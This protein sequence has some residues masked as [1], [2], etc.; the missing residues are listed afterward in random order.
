MDPAVNWRLAFARSVCQRLRRYPGLRAVIVGGSV[1]RGYADPFSDLEMPLFW[2]S[3]PDDNKRLALADDLGA[4]FAEPYNGPAQED[5]L[6]IQGFKVDFWHNTVACEEQVF[7]DVLEGYD[8]DL[9]SSNFMDTIR[10]CIPLHG[11]ELI[12]EWKQRA[13]VYPDELVRRNLQQQIARLEDGQL[14]ILAV[15]ANPTELFGRIVRFQ[16][17]LFLILLA[18]NREYFPAF[19]WLYP[20]LE[21]LPLK[22]PEAAARF[23]RAFTSEWGVAITDTRQ[24]IAE[25]LDLV[26]Q[27]F[28]GCGA[29]E[30]RRRL[31]SRRQ[32]WNEPIMYQR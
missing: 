22:P 30:A 6:L 15:R 19:K 2:E 17:S 11:E 28:P 9:G 13:Q 18:L 23:R 21:R 32:V 4:E 26:E 7:H 27:Q 20:A 24:M 10:S 8:T 3:L 25:T 5:N 31:A 14:E 16:Q 29:V 12:Q 1:A